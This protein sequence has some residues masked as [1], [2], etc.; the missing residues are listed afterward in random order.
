LYIIRMML[1]IKYGEYSNM[2]IPEALLEHESRFEEDLCQTLK[3]I[4]VIAESGDTDQ[5]IKYIHNNA[6]L[7]KDFGIYCVC[8][9]L[10]SSLFQSDFSVHV[11]C[12]DLESFM[13]KHIKCPDIM[14]H[15]FVRELLP[16]NVYILLNGRQS[17]INAFDCIFRYIL[18]IKTKH[19][20]LFTEGT[21]I[22]FDLRYYSNG[23]IID[24]ISMFKY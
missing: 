3:K 14:N 23:G 10:Y 11:V 21:E 5:I 24:E 18:Y 2:F 19:L 4:D 7:M 12:A 15:D 22:K 13:K 17:I 9:N 1:D 16:T 6:V 20:C 8:G